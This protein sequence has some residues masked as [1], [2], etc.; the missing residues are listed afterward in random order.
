M[1]QLHRVVDLGL[2]EPGL[3]VPGG[4]DLDGDALP[5]PRPPPH[6][7]IAAFACKEEE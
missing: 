5:H 3:F 1:P 2:P 4:E 6:F 7:P